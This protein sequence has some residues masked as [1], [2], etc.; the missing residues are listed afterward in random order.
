[1]ILGL[2]GTKRIWGKIVSQRKQPRYLIQ[3][4]KILYV[5]K[6]I[7]EPKKVLLHLIKNR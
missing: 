6:N 5:I 7:Y 1:M 2:G 3:L 4:D